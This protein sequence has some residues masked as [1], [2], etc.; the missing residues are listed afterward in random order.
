MMTE[1]PRRVSGEP[2]YGD[3][4]PR[5]IAWARTHPDVS[6]EYRRPHWQALIPEENGET[7]IT[8]MSLRQLMDTLEKL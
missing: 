8:R 7:V 5:L 6:V 3:Q 1:P 4:V 2:D